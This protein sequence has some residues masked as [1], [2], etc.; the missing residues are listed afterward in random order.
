MLRAVRH[1]LQ[2]PA[3]VTTLPRKAVLFLVASGEHTQAVLLHKAHHQGLTPNEVSEQL[4]LYGSGLR[5]LSLPPLLQ[6][7]RGAKDVEASTKGD[8]PRGKLNE[9][10][11]AVDSI[12]S[13]AGF[14]AGG[15]TT[16]LAPGAQK[17]GHGL[18]ER[19][20]EQVYKVRFCQGYELVWLGQHAH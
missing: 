11:W 1:V 17:E 4:G 2:E 6:M 12:F 5:A 18:S 3:L 8:L 9:I 14:L 19:V 13:S 15:F 20:I 7:V 16:P 10:L